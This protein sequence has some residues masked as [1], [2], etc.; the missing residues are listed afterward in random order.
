MDGIG[1]A[2]PWTDL[3]GQVFL[4]SDQFMES[5]KE[6]LDER[7]G[8]LEI[9]K[10]QRRPLAKSLE[11]YD[12]HCDSRTDAMRS[13]Y[14]SGSYTLKEIADYHGVHYST[15]SRAVRGH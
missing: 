2:G 5:M 3:R 14:S 12:G 9:P 7:G 11:Y 10:A 15:V 6:K 8:D 13:A 4:G 1:K